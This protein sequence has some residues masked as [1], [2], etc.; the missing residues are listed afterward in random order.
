M[1]SPTANNSTSVSGSSAMWTG[2]F[3]QCLRWLFLGESDPSMALSLPEWLM[4]KATT[5]GFLL[6]TML[7]RSLVVKPSISL[8]AL[9]GPDAIDSTLVRGEG[10]EDHADSCDWLHHQILTMN[11]PCCSTA[12]KVGDEWANTGGGQTMVQ[13]VLDFVKG[14]GGATPC[15]A[16]VMAASILDGERGFFCA[17]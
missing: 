8:V 13:P 2:D 4:F 6:E 16:V 12:A 10:I 14:E 1:R 7:L 9:N 5:S 11:K 17:N 3:I 15:A